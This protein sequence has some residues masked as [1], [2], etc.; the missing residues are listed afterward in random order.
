MRWGSTRMGRASSP[1]MAQGSQ[2]RRA[3]WQGTGGAKAASMR[4]KRK[5]ASQVR[6]RLADGV[7]L[8]DWIREPLLAQHRSHVRQT[9]RSV[10]LIC[11]NAARPWHSG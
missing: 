9:V 2:G 5:G 3:S 6:A 8:S 1:E 7:T 4:G 11:A 10:C